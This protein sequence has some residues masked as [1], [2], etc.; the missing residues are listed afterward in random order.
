MAEQGS[1][2]FEKIVPERKVWTVAELTARLRKQIEAAF[3]DV[4]VQGEI[5]NARVSPN[6]HL[7]FTL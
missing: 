4:W 3:P 1:L 6:G 5:S 2:N 7:Y